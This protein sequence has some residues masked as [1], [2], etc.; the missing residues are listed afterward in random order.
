[1]AVRAG[2]AGAPA[3][4]GAASR[5]PAP[6]PV[7][8]SAGPRHGRLRHRRA[9]CV[10]VGLS[11][12]TYSLARSFLLQQRD[13][14]RPQ[15]GLQQRRAGE[16]P[17]ARPAGRRR[18]AS[19]TTSAPRAAGSRSSTTTAELVPADRRPGPGRPA[20]RTCGTPCCSATAAASA[21]TSTAT[22]TSPSAST[23]PPDRRRLLR[24]VPDRQPAADAAASIGT[25]AGRRRH[26]RRRW[27]PPASGGGP[28]AASSTRCRASP[29]PPASWP[30]AGS[31][32]AS[33]DEQDPDL[34]RLVTSFND[35]ADAVQ[36]RIEREARFASDVSHEL[37][38]PLTALTAAVEVLDGRRD[39]LPARSQQALDVV[40]SQ[41]RRFD[42]MVLDLLEISRLDA[43]V[44]E[45]HP[46][47]VLLGDLGPADRRPLRLRRTCP[48]G[49]TT[50]GPSAR[51]PST[52]GA[53]SASSPTCSTTP[54]STAAV[55]RA[56][57]STTAAT[58]PSTSWWRTPA[59]A[60]RQSER[61]RIFE[62]FAR[63]TAARHRV[64]TGLGLA[65][66]V[67]ARR[68]ARGRRVG[69]G[70]ARR[71][72]PL[73]GG[74][75]GHDDGAGGDGGVR[76]RLAPGALLTAVV[77]GLAVAGCGV[78]SDKQYSAI[79][80]KDI[81]FGIADT[82]TTSTTTT[83]PP[84]TTAPPV[85]TT[86]VPTDKRCSTSSTTTSCWRCQRSLPKPVGPDQVVVALQK[87]PDEKDLPPGCA[88]PSPPA[89]S[90]A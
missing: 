47:P 1:M 56:S 40:I 52:S 61:T 71:R 50:A 3:A 34:D 7:P 37:R 43:G 59:P 77:L 83:L 72:R 29:T 57:P 11:L 45:F 44:T 8:R 9:A 46:E 14:A 5:P 51:S 16:G 67:R 55:R 30:R 90:A 22:R 89:R 54:S 4:S 32:P 64:G 26:G 2:P 35:M 68:R 28:A 76:H 87:G 13:S 65:L 20:R 86:T 15:P 70:P 60:C 75:P 39:D 23:S 42:Q 79:Q 82:T 62:R 53:S 73:R 74:L 63:G 48:S 81:P 12:I 19:S 49:S 27:P 66:V 6:P 38:S 33:P 58:A 17:P 21:T 25:L 10:A 18:P 85:T 88:R 24:G 31:T 41:V 78:P 69:R 80:P 36:D 84:V